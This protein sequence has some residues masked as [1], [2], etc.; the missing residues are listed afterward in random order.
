MPLTFMF[1]IYR[2]VYPLF[3]AYLHRNY[4]Q[5]LSAR[6]GG[7]GQVKRRADETYRAKAPAESPT[8]RPHCRVS[9]APGYIHR[10]QLD[11]QA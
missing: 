2:S 8:I 10:K 4:T 3:S 9:L 1:S 5:E 11:R 6:I 7:N